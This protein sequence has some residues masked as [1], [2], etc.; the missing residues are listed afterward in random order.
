MVDVYTI[1][2][3]RFEVLMLMSLDKDHLFLPVYCFS[4]KRSSF[5]ASAHP[6]HQNQAQTKFRQMTVLASKTETRSRTSTKRRQT[7]EIAR[8]LP[9]KNERR[10]TMTLSTSST[11]AMKD[12]WED[13]K[14]N[15]KSSGGDAQ[16][17]TLLKSTCKGISNAAPRCIPSNTGRR[18]STAT[19]A[20][21]FKIVASKTDSGLQSRKTF[22]GRES[23]PLRKSL[24]TPRL[25][26]D[27]PT[28]FGT[29]SMRQISNF[30]SRKSF[31]GPFGATQR[32]QDEKPTARAIKPRKS[33][34]IHKPTDAVKDEEVTSNGKDN[35]A[36][37]PVKCKIAGTTPWVSKS[38]VRFS[39]PQRRS[40]R[41]VMKAPTKTPL[42][43]LKTQAAMRQ[44]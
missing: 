10:Q 14:N 38:S 26:L 6:W 12:K 41:T 24:L 17:C 37:K 4:C 15:W 31:A 30:R 35:E 25:P 23:K 20:S 22:V 28:G 33:M 27:K 43:E 39:T 36:L 32:D 8:P 44:V 34:L 5:I 13:T 29:V 2:T 21:K 3:L 7:F 18:N 1:L 19:K 16:H 42:P 11:G 40:P 9:V